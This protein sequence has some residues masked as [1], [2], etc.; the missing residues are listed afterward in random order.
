MKILIKG[1]VEMVSLNRVK[2]AHLER[3]LETGTET[4][5]KG[6]TKTKNSKTTKI[7]RRV[8]KDQIKPS[9]AV[10]QNS[11]RKR[12]EPAVN[13]QTRFDAVKIGKNLATTSQHKGHRV[14]LSKQFTPY[15][16]PHL[17]VPPF[18]ALT[19]AAAVCERIHVCLYTHGVKPPIQP[20]RPKHR[21]LK[22]IW[23]SP[24][25]TKL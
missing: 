1:K 17:R 13:T 16:A 5:R 4:Q 21:M 7:V 19:G 2:P 22:T 11:D 12:A 23:T 24:T 18:P 14:N 3:E 20:A 25:V 8:P 9:S 10:T 15:V 6:Q